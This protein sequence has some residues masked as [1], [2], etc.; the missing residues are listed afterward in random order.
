[1][2]NDVE[3]A[4]FA[5][6]GSPPFE[7]IQSAE[8]R[9]PYVFNSP[10]SGRRYPKS[11]VESSKLSSHSLRGSEDVMVDE[12]FSSVVR[13]GAPMLRANF[14]RC[15]LDVNREPYELD[16]L[17]FN[18][19]LPG[20]AN[21]RSMRVAGGLGT[22]PRL[23]S[24][25]QP[26]YRKTPKLSDALWRIENIYR[27]YHDAL[28]KLIA[29][30]AVEFGYC[31]LVDCHSMPSHGGKKEQGRRPDLII[32]DRYG[33]SCHG[34]IT[35]NLVSG[36]VKHGYSAARNKPYAGGFIT[37]H[38]GRPLKGLHTVQVEV[39][40]ALYMDEGRLELSDGFSLLQN[41]IRKVVSD[42]VSIPDGDFG[43]LAE[44]AE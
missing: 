33:T 32:G 42:L 43:P 1:M 11:F 22:I 38:Y 7:V 19:R 13:I 12:L 3:L 23:V 31:V 40:R 29:K 44:A 36:F 28:R 26:I 4:D 21:S 20:H 25:N 8:Q 16:P 15:W 35:S 30:T 6:T 10:H 27:P 17:L 9:V 2:K 34:S 18:E 39:N 14:P 41:D 24:E 37:E 5:E